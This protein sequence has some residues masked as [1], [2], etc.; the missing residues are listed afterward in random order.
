MPLRV[1]TK[2]IKVIHDAYTN[3]ALLPSIDSVYDLRECAKAHEQVIKPGRNG[4][5]LLKINKNSSVKELD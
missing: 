4:A 3:N 5:V 1:R 2:L